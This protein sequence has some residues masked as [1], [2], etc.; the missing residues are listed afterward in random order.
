MAEN[1]KTTKYSN[2]DQIPNEIDGM[3]WLNLSTGAYCWYNRQCSN[4]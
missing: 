4:I 3:E 1:L 2:G